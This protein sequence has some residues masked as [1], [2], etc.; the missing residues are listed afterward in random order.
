MKVNHDDLK[1]GQKVKYIE[2]TSYGLVHDWDA[3]VVR[4]TPKRV[5]I[6]RDNFP[7]WK[8]I[9]VNPNSLRDRR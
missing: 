7:H 6:T 8:P 5:A 9:T 2:R 4:I 1:V 3:T